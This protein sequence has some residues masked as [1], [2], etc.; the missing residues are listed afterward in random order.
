MVLKI[1]AL[2]C[3]RIRNVLCLSNEVKKSAG[4]S[5]KAVDL[6]QPTLLSCW[7][8]MILIL[9]QECSVFWNLLHIFFAV[10]LHLVACSSYFRTLFLLLQGMTVSCKVEF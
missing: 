1:S 3:G 4:Q 2:S 5:S 6:F 8:D 10:G 7:C 9:H